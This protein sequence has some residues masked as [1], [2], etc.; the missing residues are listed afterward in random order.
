VNTKIKQMCIL[1]WY[2][3]ICHWLWW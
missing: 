1:T 2:F 3:C